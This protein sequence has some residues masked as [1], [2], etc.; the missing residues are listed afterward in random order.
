MKTI[1]KLSLENF[2]SHKLTVLNFDQGLNAIV[3]PT[4]SGKTAILR[5]L[6][7]VLYN[8]P[9]GDA[10]IRQGQSSVSVKL[11]FT[12][13]II[14]ER[15]RTKSKNGYKITYANGEEAIF[16]GFGSQVPEEVYQASQ[17]PK[18]TLRPGETRSL[19][20]AEQLEGPFLLTDNASL[21]AAA[22]GK[23][24]QAD[25]IDYALG[26]VNLDLRNKKKDQKYLEDQ[27][28][29]TNK[30]LEAYSYLED[31]GRT[32]KNLETIQD[33]IKIKNQ[34]L[35]KLQILDQSYKNL[36][37]SITSLRQIKNSLKNLDQVEIFYLEAA[38][39]ISKIKTLEEAN[40]AY[41][42]NQKRLN[43]TEKIQKALAQVDQA[44]DLEEK[45]EKLNTKLEKLENIRKN[46][47]QIKQR[48]ASTKE[49][50]QK[51][52][53]LDQLL[54]SYKQ[55]EKLRTRLENYQKAEKSLN[56][57]KERIKN[58]EKYLKNFQKLD[59][60]DQ[61]YLQINQ[62]KEKLK[63]LK[64]KNSNYKNILAKITAEKENIQRASRKIVN[65]EKTYIKLI[66]EMK[67]CPTCKRPFDLENPDQII[68]HL[69]E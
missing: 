33:Q 54:A 10:F 26:Q 63:T 48:T 60:V 22:L 44:Q 17:M 46:Q 2:Q 58:G 3:G 18:I 9:Q 52:K 37:A 12:D 4:D 8:E 13:G 20:M 24:V 36:K 68:K 29:K 38:N 30:D 41:K 66:Q 61:A 7:W 39:K 23:L 57:L 16:E 11:E 64:E 31:L 21:K 15:Y 69:S 1:K 27:L 35:E 14:I 65:I 51:L 42:E 47:E 40:K 67:V 56:I 62:A 50:Y 53:N 25:L 49:N 19:N 32:I 6:K 45:I 34:D 5:A 59:Q 55:L 43:I 28:E